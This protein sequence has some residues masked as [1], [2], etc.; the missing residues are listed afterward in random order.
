VQR[1]GDLDMFKVGDERYD[2]SDAVVSGG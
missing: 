2:I 1:E